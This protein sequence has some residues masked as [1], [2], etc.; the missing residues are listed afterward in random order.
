MS[1]STKPQTS[2]A[3]LDF[4]LESS[5]DSNK[6]YT[7][8]V[9]KIVNGTKVSKKL[10]LDDE[11]DAKTIRKSWR[12]RVRNGM[13]AKSKRHRNVRYCKKGTE[14][15]LDA[16]EEEEEEREEMEEEEVEEEEERQK[17]KQD[18]DARGSRG[19][20]CGKTSPQNDERDGDDDVAL[21]NIAER[22]KRR[23]V[24]AEKKTLKPT[25]AESD[26]SSKRSTR[27][28]VLSER[29]DKSSVVEDQAVV[30]SNEKLDSTSKRRRMHATARN[31]A[32]KSE[33]STN[34]TIGK[35]VVAPASKRSARTASSTK[36]SRGVTGS[37]SNGARDKYN[38]GKFNY[39]SPPESC[40]E[41]EECVLEES[42][43]A[44]SSVDEKHER[45]SD[46]E[47][48]EEQQRI[49]QVLLQERE[50]YEL[51]RRLQAKFDELEQVA[52]RTRRSRRVVEDASFDAVE[53]HEIAAVRAAR[54][55][56]CAPTKPSLVVRTAKTVPKKKRGRPP[57]RVK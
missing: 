25:E 18:D 57:K 45:L 31:T 23:K 34:A 33:S 20:S 8:S 47:V 4:I 38:N 7:K 16:K 11:L 9:N 29:R 40:D 46:E 32:E 55:A 48:I 15:T 26:T 44:D 28:R 2:D 37:E 52:R 13:V 24:N 21:E 22:I 12:T 41:T 6:N 17:Q 43:V 56:R 51:A 49:E 14:L 53:L 10:S 5:F 30:V 27:K 3:R 54:K 35:V 36:I 1:K 19:S 42:N 39:D 50:D